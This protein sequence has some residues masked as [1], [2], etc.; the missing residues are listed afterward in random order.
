MSINNIIVEN[1]DLVVIPY[2]QA[3]LFLNKSMIYLKDVT[4]KFIYY[5][6]ISSKVKQPIGLFRWI[7]LYILNDLE[8]KMLFSLLKPALYL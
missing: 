5:I 7:Q 2:P 4:G 3:T 6:V 1:A 8:I